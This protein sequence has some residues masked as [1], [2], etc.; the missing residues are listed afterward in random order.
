MV[1]IYYVDFKK[2]KLI[3]KTNVAHKPSPRDEEK[4]DYFTTLI[5]RGLTQLLVDST[6]TGVSL[7]SY[8]IGNPAVQINWSHNYR[9]S[10]FEFDELGVRGTLSFNKKNFYVEL[11]WESVWMMYRPEEGKPSCRSWREDAP[12]GLLEVAEGELNGES[13]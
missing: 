5:D 4:L 1:N 10:D 11:P 13:K 7:P 9:I 2:K 6:N 3:S 8:I 12:P